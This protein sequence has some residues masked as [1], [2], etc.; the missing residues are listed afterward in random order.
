MEGP[1]YQ[2][3]KQDIAR[4]VPNAVRLFQGK[5]SASEFSVGNY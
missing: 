3:L 5:Y 4:F 2:K 1:E